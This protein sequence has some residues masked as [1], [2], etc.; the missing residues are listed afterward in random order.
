ML[1]AALPSD[2][3]ERLAALKALDI[4]DTPPEARFD[5]ITRLASRLFNVPIALVSLVDVNRQWFK[6]CY[7]LESRETPRDVSFC[8]HAILKAETMIVPDA[9]DDPRFSDNPLVTREPYIRFYAGQPLNSPSGLRVGTL[10]VI[11]RHPRQLSADE[12][13]TLQDLAAWVERELSSVELAEALKQLQESHA[14]LTRLNQVRGEFVHI[15]S[16]KFR[17]ALTGIQGFSEMI[18]DENFS[19]AEMRAYADDI[20]QDALRLNQMINQLLEVDRTASQMDHLLS[21]KLNT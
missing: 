4:L 12:Q 21:R 7:G 13:L 14:R 3:N 17:T 15:V 9:L 1:S 2:E 5:R 11:D 16:H 6:S 8:S 19:M 18:R 20:N 10:C